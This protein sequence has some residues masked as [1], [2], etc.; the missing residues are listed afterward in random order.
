MKKTLS[1]SDR[2]KEYEAVS[3]YKLMRKT[4]VIIRIDGKTFS[5]WTKHL[6]E[7]FD[8]NF[9]AAM[10]HTAKMLVNE[11]QG[12]VF[13]Y[14]QSDE[15]SIFVKDYETITTDAWFGNNLQKINSVTSSIATAQFNDATNKLGITGSKLAYFDSRVFNLPVHEVSNYFIFRQND[16]IRNSIQM[17]GQKYLGHKRCHGLKLQQV[18]DALK[19]LDEPFDWYKDLDAIYKHGYMYFRG[20][21]KIRS[22]LPRFIESPEYIGVNL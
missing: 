4:P 16:F 6:Q 10:A 19:E 14:G 15:I 2:M 11:I 5:S 18:V 3:K 12:A 8:S 22:I 9:Y 7:P 17:C 13:A 21:D 1:L 20:E